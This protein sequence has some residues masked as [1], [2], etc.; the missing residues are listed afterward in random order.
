MKIYVDVFIMGVATSWGPCVSFCAPIL[1]PY[2]A[3][4]QKG[5][6]AGLK[7]SLA[8]SL[9]R[10]IPY[11]ILSLISATLGQ[12]LIRRFYESPP[13]SIIYIA[14]GAFISLLGILIVTGKN[15]HCEPKGRSN[16][17][18]SWRSRGG[19]K[20]MI[21]LGIMVGFAPCLPLLGLLTYIAFNARDFLH[22]A[23]LGLAFGLGTLI[24]PLIL[25]GPLAGASAA[26]LFK[27]SL[28]YKIVGRAC[29]LILLYF[30]I[31]MIIRV[32]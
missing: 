29:G 3:A 2:I 4:T 19:P 28:V 12:C 22:G 24:S 21:L 6:L 7:V 8:F 17:K 30:G 11:V 5:W 25:F 1:I 9:A 18:K 16:L 20:E 26:F 31:G 27:R 13:G 32:L 15:C 10:I 23:S 14:A